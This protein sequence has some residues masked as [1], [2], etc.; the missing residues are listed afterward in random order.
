MGV[1]ETKRP[2]E[3]SVG[4]DVVFLTRGT[5]VQREGGV[6]KGVIKS[7][8]NYGPWSDSDS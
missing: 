7:R 2:N 6:V 1:E 8:V 4:V 5:D 3:P